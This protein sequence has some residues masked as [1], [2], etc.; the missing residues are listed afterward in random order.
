MNERSPHSVST[1]FVLALFSFFAVSSLFLVLI[2]ANVYK[3]IVADMDANNEMRA[4]LSYVGNKV[5]AAGTDGVQLQTFDGQKA[6]VLSSAANGED[7]KTY[8]YEYNGYL[9]ELY[10]RAQNG[11]TVGAG[12]R[13]TPVSGFS[14]EESG[15]QLTLS[16]N[17]KGHRRLTMDLCLTKGG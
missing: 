5:H 10:T 1:V 2:G 3:G 12:D 7:Y 15:G 6:L 16:V 11:F 17:G 4:S 8:I 9:M 14:M 13:I